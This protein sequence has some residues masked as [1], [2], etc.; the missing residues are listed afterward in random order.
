MAVYDQISVVFKLINKDLY[1]WVI[2]RSEEE[3][4]SKSAFIIRSL[5]KIRKSEESED[6]EKNNT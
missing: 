5:K 4:M 3:D 6:G 1:N 2:R